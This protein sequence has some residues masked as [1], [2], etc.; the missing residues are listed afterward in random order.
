MG[1]NV[2]M[3][4]SPEDYEMREKKKMKKEMTSE[5]IRAFSLLFQ[6]PKIIREWVD[7]NGKECIEIVVT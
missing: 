7:E 5:E 3:F 2:P 4:E 1:R 6:D